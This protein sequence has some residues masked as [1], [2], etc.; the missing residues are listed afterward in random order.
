[1]PRHHQTAARLQFDLTIARDHNCAYAIEF[2]LVQPAFVLE[3][4]LAVVRQHRRDGARK[5]S[6]ASALDICFPL[7]RLCGKCVHAEIGMRSG[8]PSPFRDHSNHSKKFFP[9]SR[10]HHNL[11]AEVWYVNGAIGKTPS[12]PT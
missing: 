10:I 1:M 4:M 7:M 11:A 3:Y 12:S 2:R 5:I 8:L 9:R 6:D